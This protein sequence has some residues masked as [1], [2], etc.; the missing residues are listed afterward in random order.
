MAK[1]PG[2]FKK[3]A[4]SVDDVADIARYGDDVIEG[5]TTPAY[6][7]FDEYSALT[8]TLTD[9]A[10]N[11]DNVIN[12][13]Q[14]ESG[15]YGGRHIGFIPDAIINR[16]P[17]YNIGHKYLH[18]TDGPGAPKG[19]SDLNSFRDF[20][21]GFPIRKVL[22]PGGQVDP[23]Y[24]AFVQTIPISVRKNFRSGGSGSTSLKDFM[25]KHYP[26]RYYSD[27]DLPF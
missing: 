8:D 9:A 20:M 17:G 14:L 3:L 18:Y 11:A 1:L 7:P 16:P 6:I 12:L 22:Y 13:S 10:Q 26:N 5:I 23:D 21:K 25:K 27:D 4:G 2:L 15:L 24:D 19:S